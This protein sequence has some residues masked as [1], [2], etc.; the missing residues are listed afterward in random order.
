MGARHDEWDMVSESQKRASEKYQK[1]HIKQYNFRLNTRTDLDLI[2][3]LDGINNRQGL[4]KQL[5]RAE[6]EN[7]KKLKR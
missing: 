1:E 4:I 5:L 7:R 2:R 6:M 3:F